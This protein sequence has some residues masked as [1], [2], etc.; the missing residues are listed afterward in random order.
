MVA[1][2]SH[3]SGAGDRIAFVRVGTLDNPDAF[4]P[5]V[6]IFTSTRQ[7]WVQLPAGVRVFPEFYNIPE[8]WTPEALQRGGVLRGARA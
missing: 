6:H 2:W 5:D 1:L 3:Y 8:V 7:P 4:P